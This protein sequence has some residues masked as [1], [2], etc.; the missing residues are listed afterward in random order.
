MKPFASE[1]DSSDEPAPAP[2]RAKRP[3][4][5]KGPACDRARAGRAEV[6]AEVEPRRAADSPPPSGLPD[7]RFL[8]REL[9]WLDFNARV[10]TLAE[11]RRP[12]AAGA[13]QV[14]GDLRQQ[15]GRVLHGPGGRPEAPR[16]DRPAGAQRGRAHP[17]RAAGP[18]RRAHAGAGRRGTRGASSTRSSPALAEEGI[19]IAALGRPDR[20]PSARGCDATSG[21]RSSRC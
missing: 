18:D 17:A 1:P 20:R 7:D 15:P 19:Q 16:R 10:L 9:S 4:R 5:S 8:N 13:G 6:K 21:T 11:D 14:P 2:A 12:A 3:A